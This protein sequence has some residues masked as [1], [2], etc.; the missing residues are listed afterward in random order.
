MK[1]K[2]SLKE[3]EVKSFVTSIESSKNNIKGGGKIPT[4][5]GC[6]TGNYPTLG[7]C[8]RTVSIQC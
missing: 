8:T 4:L 1:K 6:L 7:D 2:V 3:I 5:E